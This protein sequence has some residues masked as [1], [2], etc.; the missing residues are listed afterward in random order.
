M[1]EIRT[2]NTN[3]HVRR[4]LEEA[5]QADPGTLVPSTVL[6]EHEGWDSLGAVM[7]IGLVQEHLGV[8]LSVGD[9]R[10][11]ATVADLEGCVGRLL[12]EGSG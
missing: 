4:L 1:G 8:A 7:F 6:K 10:A 5:T 9:L 12:A 3:E 2:T 11:C